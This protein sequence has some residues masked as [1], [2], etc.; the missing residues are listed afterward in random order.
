MKLHDP[1]RIEGTNVTIGRRVHYVGDETAPGRVFVAVYRDGTGKQRCEALK[2]ASRLEARKR[3]L[4]VHSR[5]EA[6]EARVVDARVTVE[7]LVDAYTRM[8][9]SKGVAPTTIRK[10][11]ADLHKL[12]RFCKERGV[13]LATAF[14]RDELFQFR[15]WLL[16]CDYAAKTVYHCV[17]LAKQVFKWAWQEQKIRDYP[18]AAARIAKAKA[19][20]QPC[21]TTEQVE[22]ILEKTTGVERA[23]FATLAYAGL[24]IGEVEQLQW[25]DVKLG[26]SGMFHVRRGGSNGTTKD[27]DERFVPIHPR[28][29]PLISALSRKGELVF[30]GIRERKLLGQVKRLAKQL[31][32]PK[33]QSWK[34]H[35]FRHHFA[36]MCANHHVAYR[37]ALAW[38]GHSNSEMLN[39]YYHLNDGESH[40][41]MVALA[42]PVETAK[43]DPNNGQRISAAEGSL[44]AV[45]QSRIERAL[46]VPEFAALVEVVGSETERVGFEPTYHCW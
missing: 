33:P 16:G 31:D 27:K 23:A 26:D 34:L 42:G 29:K 12:T 43:N 38:L 18:L 35:A 21:F 7:E 11:D 32:F 30:P 8:V 14:R 5:L 13:V 45:G 44:R 28:I 41:A 46:Q 1:E 37:K 2:T 4:A 3:A 25:I 36:S 9:K 40:A 39:L 17:M 20:P 10:Y 19:K 24:R 15:E 6:G 22:K